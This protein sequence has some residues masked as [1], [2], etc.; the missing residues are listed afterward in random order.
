MAEPTTVEIRIDDD[1]EELLLPE[2]VFDAFGTDGQPPAEAVGDLLVVSCTQRLHGVVAHSAEEP[3]K[4]LQRLESA[5]R[6]RFEER[7]GAS[8]GE[9]T[10]HSH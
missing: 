7:F 5:M 4:E 1:H 6:E 10:G 3:S 8:F 9:V 2:G